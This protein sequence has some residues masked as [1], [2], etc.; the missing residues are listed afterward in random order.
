LESAGEG[1]WVVYMI[2]SDEGSLYTGIT[3]DIERRWK[4]HLSGRGARH[5]RSRQPLA[6]VYLE[7]GHDR[8]SA[9]RREIAIKR[10]SVECKRS[11]PTSDTNAL[12]GSELAAH[13]R[14]D[15]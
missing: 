2:V 4:Q 10:L 15:G 3:T 7:T 8:S 1:G 14:R 12:V 9:L 5:F 6:V 13:L 11:L